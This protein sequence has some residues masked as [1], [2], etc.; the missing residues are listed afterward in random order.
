MQSVTK[1]E[2]TP[3]SDVCTA[4]V[5]AARQ[6]IAKFIKRTPLERSDPLSERFGCEVYLKMELLQKTGAFKVRGAFN[7]LLTLTL[8]QSVHGVVAVSG[9][10]H[11][12][13]VAYA[14]K[15]LGIAAL[16][17][18]PEKTPANYVEAMR[19]HGAQVVRMPT[20]AEAF[21][22]SAKYQEEGWYFIHPFDDPLVIAGQGTLG[23]EILEDC[24]QVTDVIVSVGGGG[25]AG[26]I[27]VAIK[28]ERPG[29]HIWGV[30]TEGADAMARALA[31]GRVVELPAVTSIAHTLGAPAVSHRTLRLAK[32]HL[33]S[34]T[35][36][37]DRE[38]VAEMVYLLEQMKIL[39][40]PA[41]SCTV[42]AAS[43]L[44]TQF[45]KAHHVLLVLCGG[46]VALEDVWRFRESLPSAVLEPERSGHP[47]GRR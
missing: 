12:Q 30:E 25:L 37:P 27:A 43:R 34:V 44:R 41:A 28:A 5:L 6:R 14:A 33:E 42:A 17:L 7:K 32:Q 45:S 11:G 4:D 15:A 24:P 29:V 26:G 13:G 1:E 36:V 8:A 19:G 21:R 47:N 38:A 31:A 2:T 16:I 23:L 35:V 46:N 39:T 18:V 3:D 40:E 10:N 22:E 20:L 9:G